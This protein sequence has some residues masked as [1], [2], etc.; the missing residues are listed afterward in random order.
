MF[1]GDTLA[2]YGYYG[3]IFG[4]GVFDEDGPAYIYI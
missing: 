2:F 3:F 1:R 4:A